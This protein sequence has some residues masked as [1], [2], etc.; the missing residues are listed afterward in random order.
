MSD[1]AVFIAATGQNVGKTTTSLGIFSALC[2][3]Y[4]KVGFIKPLGQ[5]YV[6]TENHDKIDKDVELFRQYFQLPEHPLDMSPVLLPKGFSRKYLDGQIAHQGLE[7]KISK[8][9]QKIKEKSDFCLVE[10]TGHMGVGSIIGLNN[11]HVAK[12]LNLEV[13]IVA[14]GGIGS[15]FDELMLNIN[16]CR[17]YGVQIRGVILNKVLEEKKEDIDHYMEKALKRVH[18]PLIASIPYQKLLSAPTIF[19]LAHIFRVEAL[20]GASESLHFLDVHFIST[21][22]SERYRRLET[23]GLLVVTH[24]SRKDILEAALEKHATHKQKHPGTSLQEGLLI[25]GGKLTDPSFIEK[26]RALN[27]PIFNVKENAYQAM[28][29]LSKYIG[30][31][32]NEDQIKIKRAIGLVE[33]H[34][35]LDLCEK[36]HQGLLA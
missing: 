32:R 22:S 34:L 6:E 7:E 3:R 26:A 17:Q 16:L 23:E 36:P 8:S 14:P 4:A 10:G 25:T 29:R 20:S 21:Q 35:N 30:K 1:N 13:I 9:F 27:I 33:E 2:K 31:L 11:A 12:L 18:I 19:D 28:E 24:H 5:R 15:S